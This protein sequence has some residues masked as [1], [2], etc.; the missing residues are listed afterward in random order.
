MVISQTFVLLISVLSMF[1][2]ERLGPLKS[3][4][5]SQFSSAVIRKTELT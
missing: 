1:I 5:P 2:R 4:H 3:V